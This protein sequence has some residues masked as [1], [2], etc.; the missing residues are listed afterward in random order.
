MRITELA[1]YDFPEPLIAAWQAQGIEKLLP[2]Q[3]QAIKRHEL[4]NNGS[5]IVSAPT[6]SGKTFIGELAAV[7]NGLKGKRAVYLVPLKALAEEKFQS[8]KKLYG[9]Y[10]LE[11]V[12]STR[13]HKEFDRE[14]EEGNFEIA[15]IVYEKFFSLLN[16]ST[17]FLDQIGV[18]VIDELQLLSDP[19]RGSNLE[20]ILTK[21]NLLKNRFQLIG[22]SAVLGK[23]SLVD[24]WLDIDLLQY[25]RRPV[26][27]RT[28][29]LYDGVFHYQTYNGQETGEEV[30][31]TESPSE[32]PDILI[33]AVSQLANS[34]EQSL[35]S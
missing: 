27:L 5:F 24:K 17:K 9:P 28:G 22:L 25:N 32:K 33:A 19:S 14:L 10:D 35:T 7:Y 30:L 3:E 34:G 26:E 13:D 4:F 23:N 11:I 20:L 1:K 18:I 8:F 21:L 29:Y 12:I 16:S 6:S 2:I 15:I 31:L